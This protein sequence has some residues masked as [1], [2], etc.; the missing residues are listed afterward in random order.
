MPTVRQV[1]RPGS[2]SESEREARPPRSLFAELLKAHRTACGLSQEALAEAAR[3]STAAVSALERGSRQAPYRETVTLLADALSLS[4]Q[5]RMRFERAADRARAQRLR[6][7]A[8]A[9]ANRTLP[10]YLGAFVGRSENVAELSALI[11][12][13][14]LVTVTGYGG[15][16]KTRIACEVVA[17]RPPDEEDDAYFIDLAPLTDG[18]LVLS[19]VASVIGARVTDSDTQLEALAASV[20]RRSLLLIADNCEHL[21]AAAA[22]AVHAILQACPNV[23]ILA[24]SRERLGIPGEAVYR[25]P[26]LPVPGDTRI[27]VERSRLYG[28]VD[29]FVQRALAADP[30]FVLTDAGVGA[31]ADICRRLGGMPLAIEIAAARLPTLG[32]WT[33]RARLSERFDILTGGPRTLPA[34]QQTL[35][36]TIA[37]SCDLLDARQRHLASQ[38]SV[39]TD[40][41][42]VEAAEA[43]CRGA[44]VRLDELLDDLSALVEQSIVSIDVGTSP[45]SRYRMLEPIR[46][47]VHDLLGRAEAAAL[48][49]RHAEWAAR[50]V[51]RWA[52][53]QFTTPR[54]LWS[55]EIGEEAENVRSAL[56]WALGPEGDEVLA[57]RIAAGPRTGGAE[58]SVVE[59]IVGRI[60]PERHP[61]TAARLWW[62]LAGAYSGAA[63]A[64]AAQRAIALFERVGDR[65]LLAV[66]Y[67]NLAMGL[68]RTGNAVEAERAIARSMALYE[69]DGETESLGYAYALTD[70]SDIYFRQGRVAE[71]RAALTRAL[72]LATALADEWL[73]T[74]LRSSLAELEFMAGNTQLAVQLGE[75]VLATARRLGYGRD[76]MTAL[77]YLAAFRLAT[78][79]LDAAA[80]ACSQALELAR[81]REDIIVARAIEYLAA[82]C[83]LRGQPVRAARLHGYFAAWC[84]RES[85]ER[86]FVERASGEILVRSLRE[87]LSEDTIATLVAQGGGLSEERAAD[88]ALDDPS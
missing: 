21:I 67:A 50:L 13:H 18:A 26:P 38:L 52:E 64:A 6:T 77:C 22:R 85:Y 2:S 31:I 75:D 39:F 47:H 72:V 1:P 29:L 81:G 32:L 74:R 58:R 61:Q 25:L 88:E 42:T 62:R 56:G 69:E 57:A 83:A 73:V 79:Q 71:Q 36:A 44:W 5:E 30:R 27:T 65:R 11:R 10:V 82:V 55:H 19:K 16:G 20:K 49:R 76:Q 28:A 24:T 70:L 80:A 53:L 87:Q 34:R 68:A 4:G 9:E 37:W 15:I 45:T 60:D 40:G 7:H 3:V 33:L 84:R 63:K 66:S 17:R 43:V 14:R 54:L 51:E 12:H 41:W 86:N 46:E 59:G 35:R 8:E 48:S 78:G 23:T